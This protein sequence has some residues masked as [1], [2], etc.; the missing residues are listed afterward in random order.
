MQRQL[1]A[2]D[3]VGRWGGEEFA[4]V[5]P[6]TTLDGA[7]IVVDRM[8]AGIAESP[9]EA[10]GRPVTIS[11]GVTALA[12]GDTVASVFQRADSALY[13]SK[14]LGRNRTTRAAA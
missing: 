14:R 6:Q 2:T 4:V 11:F 3:T 12:A 5:L 9:V 1:R 13:T 10:I 7:M 8:R